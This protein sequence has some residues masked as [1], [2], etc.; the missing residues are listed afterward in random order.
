MIEKEIADHNEQF[1]KSLGKQAQRDF[2]NLLDGCIVTGMMKFV[3]APKGDD[4]EEHCGVFKNVH[5]EQW[6]TNPE[7][8]SYAG[9][10]YANLKGQW[11]E[12]PYSC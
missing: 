12:V 9:F 4:N 10:I 7:G 5:V 8:D 2:E 6:S 1:L 3:N 11:M